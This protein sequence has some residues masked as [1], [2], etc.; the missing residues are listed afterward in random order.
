MSYQHEH[1]P[2]YDSHKGFSLL[3]GHYQYWH[4]KLDTKED[5]WYQKYI[6]R[7]LTGTYILDLWA[8]DGRIA[9]KFQWTGFASYCCVDISPSLLQKSPTWTE[10]KEADITQEL[11]LEH[12]N[13]D[14]I[15]VFHTLLHISDI[16]GVFH[17]IA[18][19][20]APRGICIIAHHNERRPLLY[21]V[22]QQ[23]FKIET[24]FHSDTEIHQQAAAVGLQC[25][26]HPM[27]DTCF[28]VL[29]HGW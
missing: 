6:P 1:V 11:Y 24:Y 25:L 27:D 13:F 19:Y 18:Q 17:N 28:F 23:E 3:A 29:R 22:N 26:E 4:K 16:E 5:K 14:L 10:K 8:G 7:S 20:L 12:K 21:E 15:F 9:K 2:I